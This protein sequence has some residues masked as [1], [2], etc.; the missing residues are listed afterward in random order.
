[1]ADSS[2]FHSHAT[3]KEYTINF[4]FNCDSSNLV[5]SLDCVV[6]G[7]QYVGSTSMPFSLRFDNYKACYHKFKP[8]SLVPQKNFFRNF[9]EDR[10]HRFLEDVNINIIDRLVGKDRACER[11][12]RHKLD[13]FTS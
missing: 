2:S 13:T 1:M 4:S 8:G 10:N 6:C 9:S 5:Y 3:K 7:F 11:F 12:Y